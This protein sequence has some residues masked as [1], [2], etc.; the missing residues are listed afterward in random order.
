M[1][2]G[3]DKWRRRFVWRPRR[4]VRLLG[5]SERPRVRRILRLKEC[6]TDPAPLQEAVAR[7][8]REVDQLWQGRQI[9]V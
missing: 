7:V 8:D 1:E 4:A 2:S 6:N 3:T 9:A 5:L